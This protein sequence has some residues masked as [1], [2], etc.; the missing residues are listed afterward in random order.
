VSE[1]DKNQRTCFADDIAL[2]LKQ[3]GIPQD[4]GEKRNLELQE[5]C[6]DTIPIGMDI[7]D[8]EQ[9]MAT[10]AARAWSAMRD[11]AA[12]DG[13]ELQI[14]S[15]FRP[16]DYQAGI[17]TRKLQS[18]LCMEDILNSSAAP[19]F[20]EHHTGRALDITTP[21]YEPLEEVFENSPA[22]RWLLEKAHRFDFSLSYP[23]N[24]PHGVAY[25]PWHWCWTEKTGFS[26]SQKL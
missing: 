12:D 5:E 20:S 14:V 6:R 1:N 23:R 17:I 21:G 22:F 3:M 15:A 10:D 9:K 4:Y 11:S 24:N 8:R 18:G 25:E 16:V 26:R 7:F 13:V 2:L 19:G